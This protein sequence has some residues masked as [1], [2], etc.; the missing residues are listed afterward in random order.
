MQF[1]RLQT[2]VYS[3]PLGRWSL[4]TVGKAGLFLN[5]AS[6]SR[7]LSDAGPLGITALTSS[8]SDQSI[9]A[10][11]EIGLFARRQL[12]DTWALKVGYQGTGIGGVALATDQQTPFETQ[13]TAGIRNDSFF[14]MHGGI[15]G[16]EAAW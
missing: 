7:N 10:L 5:D 1:S 8:E 15:L 6:M 11:G 2:E 14:F 12:T 4:Q 3:R 13:T 16:L 9:A